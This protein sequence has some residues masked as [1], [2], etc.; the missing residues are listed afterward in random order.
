MDFKTLKSECISLQ[1]QVDQLYTTVC[2][3]VV[4]RDMEAL[5]LAHPD[6]EKRS[7]NCYSVANIKFSPNDQGL[8]ILDNRATAFLWIF[9]L[10]F[11]NNIR[12]GDAIAFKNTN[13]RICDLENCDKHLSL[14]LTRIKDEYEQ[15]TRWLQSNLLPD[16]SE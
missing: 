1:K 9:D 15:T 4:L 10:Q 12:L 5:C 8:E 14:E 16:P 2:K 13:Y 3:K 7:G 6:I 11:K